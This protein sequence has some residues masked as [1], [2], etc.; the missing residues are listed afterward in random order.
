MNQSD[1]VL[2]CVRFAVHMA[3]NHDITEWTVAALARPFRMTI[4]E[5]KEV[6]ARHPD[7]FAYSGVGGQD[8]Y[9]LQDIAFEME[10]W[11]DDFA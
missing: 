10:F 3:E 7:I 2:A 6:L 8:G 11:A 4:E 1:T 5:T 9:Y